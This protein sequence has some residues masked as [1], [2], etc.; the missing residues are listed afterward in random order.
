MWPEVQGM[1]I[2]EPGIHALILWWKIEN[3]AVHYT[4]T[5]MNQ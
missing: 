4:D 1:F 2:I 5:N 3:Y